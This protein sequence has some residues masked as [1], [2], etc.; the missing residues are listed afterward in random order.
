MCVC[1]F[2]ALF[3]IAT[4]L[5][6]VRSIGKLHIYPAKNKMYIETRMQDEPDELGSLAQRVLH[7]KRQSSSSCK[8]QSYLAV[9]KISC[10]TAAFRQFLLQRGH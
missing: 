3:R 9:R 5:P 2:S 10:V 8:W 1:I 7:T 4:L 6:D